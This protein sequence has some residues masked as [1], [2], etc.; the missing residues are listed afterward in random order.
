MTFLFINSSDDIV[1]FWTDD[2]I[3]VKDDVEVAAKDTFLSNYLI[4]RLKPGQQL[5][6]SM[7]L[8]V[9]SVRS[10][11]EDDSRYHYQPC[12]VKFAF[13]NKHH[14]AKKPDITTPDVEAAYLGRQIKTPDAFIFEI[15]SF[16]SSYVDSPTILSAAIDI[17]SAKIRRT[18]DG[19]NDAQIV[20]KD[21]DNVLQNTVTLQIFGE[22]HTLGNL[23]AYR[24]RRSLK[25]IKDS[26]QNF[27]SYQKKHP[28]ESVLILKVKSETSFIRI[29]L[30]IL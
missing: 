29:F 6:A 10:D 24:L 3:V 15:C 8:D 4:T 5:K 25:N 1:D 12:R 2:M 17:M 16:G 21:I 27:V 9:R 20:T 28:L 19:Y 18:L 7:Q 22:D 30:T 23:L 11:S 13:K 14:F 26:P